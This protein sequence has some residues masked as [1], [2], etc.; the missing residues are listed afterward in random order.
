MDTYRNILLVINWFGP[1]IGIIAGIIASFVL[2]KLFEG[3]SVIIAAITI[4][5]SIF[6]GI[7]GHFLIN[8]ALAIP[9]ILLNN[10]DTMENHN[11]LQ[12][13]LLIHYGIS[14]Q[15]IN[16]IIRKDK[17]ELKELKSEETFELKYLKEIENDKENILKSKYFQ[18]EYNDLIEELITK[19]P[20]SIRRDV[21]FI[22]KNHGIEIAKK[23]VI[24]K[25]LE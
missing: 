16:D 1:I 8:V 19:F 17:S 24:K 15:K 14:E 20:V 12:K 9:F 2:Y 6:L 25:L 3:Y 13:Q 21:E 10:G 22:E 7:I 4:I 23:V 11:K 18:M 5:C